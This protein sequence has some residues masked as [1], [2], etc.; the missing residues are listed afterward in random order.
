M[1]PKIKAAMW[2][3]A[4]KMMPHAWYDLYGVFLQLPD[5]VQAAM[6]V[7]SKA[8]SASV[9]E[10]GVCGWSKVGSIETAKRTRITTAKTNK[11]VNVSG[12]QWAVKQQNR[13]HSSSD[14]MDA[15]TMFD[16]LNGMVEKTREEAIAR[17]LEE[18][19]DDID[20]EA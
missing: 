15:L 13:M 14:R 19:N 11:L 12:W 6:K 1:H 17:G 20:M 2:E 5:F 10:Q 4:G 16:A 3:E 18:G 8:S 7:T 9:A